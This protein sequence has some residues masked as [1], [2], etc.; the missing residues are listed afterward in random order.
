[1]KKFLLLAFFLPVFAFAVAGNDQ[2]GGGGNTDEQQFMNYAHEGIRRVLFFIHTYPKYKGDIMH[3]EISMG[4]WGYKDMAKVKV[5]FTENPIFVNG[6]E[7]DAMNL[8]FKIIVS[9]PRWKTKTEREKIALAAHEVLG[10]IN[11]KRADP[12]LDDT[13]YKYTQALRYD[14]AVDKSFTM[15]H[16]GKISAS[17]DI[18]QNEI[19]SKCVLGAITKLKKDAEELCTIAGYKTCEMPHWG[20]Y[21]DYNRVSKYEVYCHVKLDLI[22]K[23]LKKID[24]YFEISNELSYLNFLIRSLSDANIQFQ[25]K[26]SHNGYKKF[27]VINKRTSGSLK[28]QTKNI[29]MDKAIDIYPSK[30]H[31]LQKNSE[32]CSVAKQILDGYMIDNVLLHYS[33]RPAKNSDGCLNGKFGDPYMLEG[34]AETVN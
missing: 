5:E 22:G 26:E 3:L 11:W 17:E 25:Y 27:I 32:R 12:Y 33:C 6:I 7:K 4:F 13:G 21:E 8:D 1:M 31:N 19:R 23:G 2:G 28:T 10:A 30:V 16:Y 29:C 24:N 14:T 15:Y 9:K 20:L 18:N 34:Y